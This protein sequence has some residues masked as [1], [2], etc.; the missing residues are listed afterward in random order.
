MSTKR[1]AGRFLRTSML[2]GAAAIAALPAVAQ[3]GE[4][5][6]NIIVTG[7]RLNQA[8]LNSPSP[9]FQVGSDE[10]ASRG[11]TRI[12]DLVNILP[13]AFVAQTSQIANGAT[14]TSTVNLRNLDAVRTL[15][16]IDGKRMPYGSPIADGA[17]ANLDMIPTQLVDRVDVVTG[18]ASAVYGSDAI[19]GVVNF[20][21]KRDFEGFMF[22]GQVG[23]YQDGNR[24]GGDAAVI[25]DALA[26]SENPVADSALDG[27]DVF[28][29]ATFGSNFADGRG[30]VTTY[31]SY[32]DQNEVRQGARDHGGCA[33]GAN[34]GSLSVDGVA[35]IG[36]STFRRFDTNVAGFPSLFQLENG[37][38]VPRSGGPSQTFNFQPENFYQRPVERFS[39]YTMAHYEI[40]EDVEAYMD[41][42]YVTNT[43]D[44]QIAFSGTFG[45]AFQIN[46]DNPLLNA[47]IVGLDSQPNAV[48]S[49]AYCTDAQVA[50]GEDVD[51]VN[52]RRNVEGDPRN[53]TIDLG[54]LRL[55]GGFR[56][57]IGE[58]WNWDTFGQFARTSLTDTS[59][60]D[61]NFQRLQDSIFL[62]N[63]AE[64][65][66]VCRSG[67]AGCVPYNIF[68]R[69]PGGGSLVTP[70]AV[71]YIQ[72]VGIST[73]NTEQIVIGGN[74]AGD[75]G[76]Y[77]VKLPWADLGVQALVG[78][79]YREDSIFRRSDDVSK[80]PGGLGL[81]GVGGGTLDIDGEVRVQEIYA[82]VQI[83]IAQGRPFFEELSLN[84][85]YRFS[86]YTNDG[87]G[88]R[89]EFTTNTFSAGVTWSP[90]SDLLFRGQFQ[91]A[92]RA[93]NVFD[94]FLDLNTDLFEPATQ[95][96]GFVDPCAG[97]F[98]FTDFNSDGDDDFPEPQATAAQCAF[99]GVTAA[100]YG[101]ISDNPAGQLNSVSGGN[102]LL[103]PES[104]DTFTVG[105]VV[106][107][108]FLDGFSLAVDYYDIELKDAI[109]QVP[110]AVSLTRCIESGDPEFCNFIQ[111]DRFGSLYID[112]S[113]FEGIRETNVNIASET[114]R[115]IDFEMNYRYDFGEMGG[116]NVNYVS[117]YLLE[118]TEVALPGATPTECEGK[119]GGACDNAEA[120]SFRYTHRFLTT[121]Q[122]PYNV[123]V[124]AT[125]RYL[126][127]VELENGPIDALLSNELEATH[128]LDLSAQWYANEVATMRFGINNLLGQDP[129]LT[130]S[131]GNG[132]AGNGNTY[133]GAYNPLGRFF[134]VG[135][136]LR[137]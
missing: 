50:A 122:S 66:V 35:C 37:N 27:R 135:L 74:I 71:D 80:I 21:L 14:G 44:A 70:E 51:F 124:T 16:L 57:K 76:A 88:V 79:E 103:T 91:R 33:L 119:Y 115:G 1:L 3:D 109:S 11:V 136:N 97:D 56:G 58:N 77:G 73:G 7:S 6:D 132:P 99:T 46:C 110:P 120:P 41:L 32:Q 107:P 26:L 123:D 129:R 55:V 89:N 90:V 121:W 63:D 59:Q 20:I 83:P 69:G 96:N 87:A 13:Q 31:L 34:S 68:Q 82:E 64:G 52:F 100:Q 38:F 106:Q 104:A 18:G 49:D 24:G 65:N 2:S 67:N 29:S 108:S 36:S 93:P 45:R 98:Q 112:N 81:T 117:S 8:N 95:P 137:L 60:N 85:A 54:S 62:V 61:L 28:V 40:T 42:A 39:L 116:L 30:N 102:P 125:W 12:E 43:T 9:V 133:P 23:F 92:V 19:A 17:P 86:D 114:R 101:T 130:E 105:V 118:D 47:P 5:D 22:D 113:N 53:S 25:R 84:G 111:R 94:L 10:I 75:L 72:G 78:M 131:A 128:Y 127:G 4:T 48:L 134:F 15:V 126:S